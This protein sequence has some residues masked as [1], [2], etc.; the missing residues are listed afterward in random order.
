MFLLKTKNGFDMT[1]FGGVRRILA[2]RTDK[3]MQSS[4]GDGGKYPMLVVKR[5]LDMSSLRSVSLVAMRR[6]TEMHESFIAMVELALSSVSAGHLVTSIMR[7]LK[8]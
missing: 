1:C 8:A 3:G 5:L 6:A 4:N 7:A 2:S